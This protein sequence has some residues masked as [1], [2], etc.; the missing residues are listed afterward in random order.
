MILH[1]AILHFSRNLESVTV[2]KYRHIAIINRDKLTTV[3]WFLYL[4]GWSPTTVLEVVEVP[5]SNSDALCG[6]KNRQ[7]WDC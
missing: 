1:I 2:L 4:T 5:I 7:A 6:K 3:H